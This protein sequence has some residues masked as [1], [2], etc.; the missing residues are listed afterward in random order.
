M[1]TTKVFRFNGKDSPVLLWDEE[2]GQG[3]ASLVQ[4]YI[5]ASRTLLLVFLV[6]QV[7]RWFSLVYFCF[8]YETL[9]EYVFLCFGFLMEKF[10][11]F[12]EIRIDFIQKN[13][14]YIL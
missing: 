11:K 5:A 9:K 2:H 3:K 1:I 4:P 8:F 13:I 10:W 7:W 14:H 12:I 6:V